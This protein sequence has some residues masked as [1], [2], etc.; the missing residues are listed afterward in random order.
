MVLTTVVQP[1][2]ELS[3]ERKKVELK[4]MGKGSRSR[5][6]SSHR[7]YSTRGPALNA[8]DWSPTGKGWYA[9][10]AER[11]AIGD[12]S[13]ATGEDAGWIRIRRT[14]DHPKHR[15]ETIRTAMRKMKWDKA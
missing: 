15:T 1:G 14:E 8:N 3:Q 7:S 11:C 6:R 13:D 2:K 10:D 4:T 5:R 9:A 12:A